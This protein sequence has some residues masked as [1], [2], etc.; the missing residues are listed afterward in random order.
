MP[1]VKPMLCHKLPEG[2]TV[3]RVDEWVAD[4]KFDGHRLIVTIGDGSTD[5][6]ASEKYVQ[7]WSRDG[8]PRI[9]PTHIREALVKFPN[10][11]YDGELLVIGQR[12]YGVTVI[13]NQARLTLVLFDVL[14]LLGIRTTGDAYRFRRAYLEEIFSR[15]FAQTSAVI[16]AKQWSINSLKDLEAARDEVWARDGEGLIVKRLGGIYAPGKRSKDILK[17]KALRHAVLEVV[18]FGAGKGLI[19]D[20]GPYAM[21]H[22]RDDD[23]NVTSVK[24]RSDREIHRLEQAAKGVVGKHPWIGRRLCVD[25]QERTPDGSYRHIRWDRWEDE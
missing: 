19:V 6:L 9:L 20:R 25:Y 23:G 10:G 18:G 8:L 4:E 21:V 14:E 15:D 5:L 17:V 1:F 3:S 24:T 16:I 22:L 7:A 12:S 11:T 13:E 2:F